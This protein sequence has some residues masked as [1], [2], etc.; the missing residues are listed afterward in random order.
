MH[1]GSPAPVPQPAAAGR[2]VETVAGTEVLAGWWRRFGG[3][4]I[5][6]VIVDIGVFVLSRLIRSADIA[7]RG[8]LSPR[9]HP[10]T[11]AAQ[12]AVVLT[13]LLITLGYPWVLL[14]RRGQT[15]GMTA[16]GVRAIDR[17]SGRPLTGPQTR[18]RMMAFFCLTLL[19][20]QIADV[21]GFNNVIGPAPLSQS[22][23]R[24]VAVAGLVVTA[25]W[26]LG[27][28][29]RQT[30]QDKVAGTVVVRTRR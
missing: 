11:A 17:V 15:V 1:T 26:P 10:M 6:L 18:R 4:L 8:P 9:L 28:G 25:L 30:L 22:V 7:L 23:F 5:D 24:L 12:A 20:Q 21:I 16:A 27:S 2:P 19:W 3:Y 29:T 14:R 13:S